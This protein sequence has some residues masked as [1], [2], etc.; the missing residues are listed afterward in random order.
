MEP[1]DI[2]DLKAEADR[3][4]RRGKPRCAAA[5]LPAYF[6]GGAGAPISMDRLKNGCTSQKISGAF[7]ETAEV[8]DTAG[9]EIGFPEIVI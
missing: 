3:M 7:C 4:G 2:A 8:S 6:R 1:V 5:A 9:H